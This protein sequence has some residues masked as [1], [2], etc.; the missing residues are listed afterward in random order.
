MSIDSDLIRALRP[1]DLIDGLYSAEAH[2]YIW[3]EA[4]LGYVVLLIS[5]VR[6]YEALIQVDNVGYLI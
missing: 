1:L 2:W 4:E 5:V 6:L 3:N